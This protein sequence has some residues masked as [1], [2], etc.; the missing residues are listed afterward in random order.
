MTHSLEVT[1]RIDPLF[2]S[3]LSKWPP[4]SKLSWISC[5]LRN[6]IY[7][8]SYSDKLSQFH[9]VERQIAETEQ[10][11]ETLYIKMKNEDETCRQHIQVYAK[12]NNT[13]MLQIRRYEGL[14][15]NLFIK[16]SFLKI[17]NILSRKL[18]ILIFRSVSDGALSTY[19]ETGSWIRIWNNHNCKFFS[20]EI[21]SFKIELWNQ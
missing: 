1:S 2:W 4:F 14:D 6:F 21:V 3:D 9:T 17:L 10:I 11:I 18:K 8:I 7:F 15:L 19:N 5:E 13:L 12:E 20:I 16:I